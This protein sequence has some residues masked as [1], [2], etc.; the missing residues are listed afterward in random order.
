M[1]VRQRVK[2]HVVLK[3]KAKVMWSWHRLANDF[4]VMKKKVTVKKE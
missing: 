1:D 4:V 2:V 3:E